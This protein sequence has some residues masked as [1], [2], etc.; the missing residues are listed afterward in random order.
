M[1]DIEKHTPGTD[2]RPESA[3]LAELRK[4]IDRVDESLVAVLAARYRLA[5][6][7]GTLKGGSGIAVLDPRR[8]AEIVRRASQAARAEG[9]PEEG[10]RQLFWAV[11]DYCR[12]GVRG[13]YRIEQMLSSERVAFRG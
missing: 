1:E 3:R 7:V 10:V 5:E 4:R 12:E 9:V 2:S 6:Q 8:E 13:Q 11:L